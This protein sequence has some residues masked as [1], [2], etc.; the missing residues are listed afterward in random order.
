MAGELFK[1]LAH[2]N[3]SHVPYR[4]NV[5][6]IT[7]VAG[8]QVTMGFIPLA[9]A[10]PFIKS[11]RLKP[12]ATLGTSRSPLMP[13][14]PTLAESG[15]PG[16]DVRNWCAVFAPA[17]TSDPIVATLNQEIRRIMKS[18]SVQAQLIREAQ[19]YTDMSPDELGRFVEAEDRKW[20]PIV[21][22]S[23]AKAE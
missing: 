9:P 3:I 5:A 14:T 4:S 23:G 6:A 18:S 8:N 11:N 19:R 20:T 1:S 10:L 17:G 15:V 12:I 16:F 21:K 2:V 22:A 7:D 13:D